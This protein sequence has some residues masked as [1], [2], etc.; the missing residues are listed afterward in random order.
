MFWA[1][2]Y[3]FH[4]IRENSRVR[5]NPE[6]SADPIIM[7]FVPNWGSRCDVDHMISVYVNVH[8]RLQERV[9]LLFSE[10]RCEQTGRRI[11]HPPALQ[12]LPSFLCLTVREFFYY[13][14]NIDTHKKRI[15]PSACFIRLR[16][17]L[18]WG[19]RSG[20]KCNT[21]GRLALF[22]CFTTNT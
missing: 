22:L 5:A 15:F 9:V 8:K 3:C 21:V 6:E 7:C 13:C 12:I 4:F 10:A 17:G 1:G 14:W 19:K 11:S 16:Q 18:K 2:F 20:K